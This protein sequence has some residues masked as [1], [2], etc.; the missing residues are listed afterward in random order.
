ML[1]AAW[2]TREDALRA[3]LMRYYGVSLDDGGARVSWRDIAAMVAH[4]PSESALRRA[5]GDG[6][7]EAERLLSQIADSTY[8]TWWQRV[9]HDGPDAIPLRRVLSPRERAERA[10]EAR[11]T[12]YTQFDMD[13]I[14]DMLGI[15]EDRR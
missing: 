7:S 9:K 3:D 1:G 12:V 8:I 11:E 5:E 10:E 2:A 6:W 14:A 15:P 13:R 4:L